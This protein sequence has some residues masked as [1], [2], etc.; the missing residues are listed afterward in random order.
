MFKRATRRHKLAQTASKRPD[1]L[2]W[3]VRN[4]LHHHA[5]LKN[6]KTKKYM[7]KKM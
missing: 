3:G 7:D 4:T 2:T 5:A 1:P 6:N